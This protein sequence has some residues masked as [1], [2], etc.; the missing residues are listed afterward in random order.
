M[1]SDIKVIERDVQDSRLLSREEKEAHLTEVAKTLKLPSYHFTN[2]LELDDESL[3]IERKRSKPDITA[4]LLRKLLTYDAVIPIVNEKVNNLRNSED[5]YNYF[6]IP[7]LRKF[8]NSEVLGGKARPIKAKKQ[9]AKKDRSKKKSQPEN[10]ETTQPEKK[11]SQP[12]KKTSQSII[13]TQ[14]VQING[15]KRFIHLEDVE[16]YSKN[17]SNDY[18]YQTENNSSILIAGIYIDQF[19]PMVKYFR[20]KF[21]WAMNIFSAIMSGSYSEEYL[22]NTIFSPYHVNENGLFN[23]NLKELIPGSKETG[24]HLYYVFDNEE[25]LSNICTSL[26]EYIVYLERIYAPRYYS[27]FITSAFEAAD[28]ISEKDKS[29]LGESDLFRMLTIM[30]TRF[31]E[32]PTLIETKEMPIEFDSKVLEFVKLIKP[33]ISRNRSVKY[34]SSLNYD[35]KTG[36]ILTL[37]EKF[38]IGKNSVDDF[39]TSQNKTDII[40]AKTYIRQQAQ[41]EA[42]FTEMRYRWI[43]INKFGWDKF[44]ELYAAPAHMYDYKRMTQKTPIMSLVP[45]NIKEILIVEYKRFEKYTDILFKNN[46]PHL[47]IEHK[48]R[49]SDNK[50]FKAK[51]WEELKKFVPEKERS[52][53]KGIPQDMINCNNCKLPLVCPHIRD[54]NE[55]EK[56]RK[57]DEEIRQFINKYAGNVPISGH[58]YCKICGEPIADSTE[59]EGIISFGINQPEDY[60]YADDE[61]RDFIWQIASNIVRNFTE[62]K[63]LQTQKYINKFTGTVVSNIYEFVF[64]IEKK[65]IKSKTSSLEEINNKK[66]LFTSI[67]VISML[68]K[69]ISENPSRLRFIPGKSGNKNAGTFNKVPIGKL[70]GMAYNIIIGTQNVLITKIEG[71]TNA[72]VQ[73]ALLKSYKVI[74]SLLGKSSI[75][76]VNKEEII[77]TLLLDPLY[78]YII[79][80]HRRIKVSEYSRKD[81]AKFEKVKESLLD[82]KNSL[83]RD[84]KEMEKSEYVFEGIKEPKF[85]KGSEDAFVR[86]MDGVGPTDVM[87]PGLFGKNGLYEGYWIKSFQHTFDYIQ[88]RMYIT[89]VMKVDILDDEDETIRVET[90]KKYQE[91]FEKYTKISKAERI[92]FDLMKYHTMRS[93]QSIPFKRSNQFVLG[94]DPQKYLS[95]AYGNTLNTK[96]NFKLAGINPVSKVGFHVHKWNLVEYTVGGSKKIFSIKDDKKNALENSGN[97][98]WYVNDIICSVCFQYKGVLADSKI[99]IVDLIEQDQTITSFYNFYANRC[100]YYADRK[101]KETMHEFSTKDVCKNCGYEK[102]FDQTQNKTYFHKWENAFKKDTEED[103]EESLPSIDRSKI[104]NIPASI[105]SPDI[106]D[107]DKWK[108]NPNIITEISNSTYDVVSKSLK[109]VKKTQYHNFWMSLGLTSDLDFDEILSGKLTPYKDTPD[110]ISRS[111]LN[112][113]NNYIY[114]LMVDYNM[115]LNYKNIAL[116]PVEI[117]E[118]ISSPALLGVLDKLPDFTKD[119]TNKYNQMKR[120]YYND[121]DVKHLS[122]FVLEFLCKTLLNIFKVSKATGPFLAYFIQDLFDAEKLFSKPKANKVAKFMAAQPSDDL[123]KDNSVS[124]AFN[125]GPEKISN[126]IY[127]GMDYDGHNEEEN[128]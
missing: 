13:F 68:V 50:S 35:L 57:T 112:Q 2:F 105:K 30:L 120:K 17:H 87:K 20:D 80:A 31:Q 66:K 108:F 19:S 6:D 12:E 45:K 110:N 18:V 90:D 115:M 85:E 52:L 47:E 8:G 67:Y 88:S 33:Y 124:D 14:N 101:S 40:D 7:V 122:N 96:F 128:T 43:Y 64:A 71:M 32:L 60:H 54:L 97:D 70:L 76:Q 15:I 44:Q 27:M 82:P 23:T 78:M 127:E 103:E 91:Y 16:E 117:K 93:Y 114:K 104:V 25:R 10:K 106:N 58:F 4:L 63:G 92:L 22:H 72:I 42:T 5:I 121:E 46:C 99:D 75:P 65:L 89:P 29:K 56:S 125:T 113:V 11:T 21:P 3:A 26:F 102:E 34:N 84:I 79:S 37:F 55:L 81:S 36:D 95:L 118:L 77:T 49:T 126:D 83:G 86:L 38:M 74:N 41:F 109:N 123:Q 59:D 48:M 51:Q 9:P 53:S 94:D 111:R 116:L 62:F 73:N 119:F 98:T 100:P 28:S 107:I 69:I 24:G 1:S 61:L 39:I